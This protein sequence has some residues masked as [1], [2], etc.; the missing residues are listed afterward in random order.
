[1]FACLII[2]NKAFEYSTITVILLNSLTLAFENPA[3]EPAPEMILVEQVFLGLYTFEMCMKILGM[4]LIF[5]RGAYLRDFWGMLD[6]TIVMSA[7]FT[8]W[9]DYQK[10]LRK[11]SNDDGEEG[12]NLNALRAF[13]VLRP[14]RTITSIKGLR[15]LVVSLLSALPMMKQTIIVLFFFFLIFA[16]GGVQML[17]GILK[18][19]CIEITTGKMLEDEE[20][21]GLLCGGTFNCPH[22]YFCGKQE[23]NPN[24]GNTNLD[25]IFY[26]LLMV[27]QSTTLE[28]WSDIQTMYQ[29]TYS[30]YIFLYFIMIVF[31]G[32]FFLMNLTLAVINASF[33]KS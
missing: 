18:R 17:Q 30:Y 3:D 13:R 28:G 6:F 4:G 7:Y 14:L 8:V 2:N 21:E 29:R 24:Y 23:T 22:G 5:N 9:N 27:F 11:D 32:A 12:M 1:M 10:S 33:T 19:R 20:G 15:M 16:I 25:N 26:A 31:I